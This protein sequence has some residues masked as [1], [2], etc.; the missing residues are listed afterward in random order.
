[1]TFH[2][3]GQYILYPWG[4]SK[5]V[6]ADVDDLDRVGRI[7]AAA[8]KQSGGLSYSVGNSASLLYA[9]SG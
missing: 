4:Y 2:S 3:Y 8:M 1:M 5:R 9:A 7:A 6:P